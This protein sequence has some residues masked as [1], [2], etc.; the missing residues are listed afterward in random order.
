ML[1]LMLAGWL[2]LASTILPLT[3]AAQTNTET[4]SLKNIIHT[5]S[6]DKEKATAL[7]DL[8]WAYLSISID[9]ALHYGNLAVLASSQI[10]DR[11]IEAQARNDYGTALLL[12]GSLDAALSELRKALEIRTV[13]KDYSGS[14]SIRLKL[15]NCYYKAGKLD[16]AMQ[17]F[18]SALSYYEKENKAFETAQVKGNIGSL[19]FTMGNYSKSIEYQSQSAELL[20]SL[21]K[22]YELSNTLVNIGNTYLKKKD[23]SNAELHYQKA[24]TS[25]TT[26]GNKYA[27]SAALNNLSNIQIGR[28]EFT[29]AIKLAQE[30]IELRASMGME[31]EL[32]SGRTTLAIALNSTGNYQKAL[33]ELK[34]AQPFAESNGLTEQLISIYLQSA[35][36]YGGIHQADSMQHYLGLYESTKNSFTE[37]EMIKTSAELETRYQTARKDSV[38]EQNKAD[39]RFRNLA[40]AGI[41]VLFVLSLAIA[42]L[43]YKQ[44]KLR[45]N[46]QQMAQLNEQRMQ[47]S[48]ELHDNIGSYLTFIKSS[49]E[50]LEPSVSTATTALHNIRQLTDETISELRKTV[51]LMNNP[52][53]SVAEFNSKLQDYYKKIPKITVHPT[54]AHSELILGSTLSTQLFRIIQ[55]A[56]NNAMKHAE[57]ESVSIQL[58]NNMEAINLTI[59][60]NGKGMVSKDGQIGSGLRNLRERVQEFSG[61]LEIFSRPN[62]GTSLQIQLPIKQ[63]KQSV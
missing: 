51:W 1:R 35:I 31:G 5:T 3:L 21:N 48:R 18:T 54:G 55:E 19:Y 22:I 46:Q 2:L 59:R 60:D 12:K 7:S 20:E 34:L 29:E 58:Q 13:I 15:G 6:S 8:C 57:A 44:Q 24:I 56:V 38:L 9:S 14:A 30:S 63:L 26:A 41:S 50:Q 28:K 16:S 10:T 42:V 61:K 49:V 52:E 4:D 33:E 62:E 47:I 40:L 43:Y 23:S 39:L 37:N 32:A 11:K 27:H 25:A 36:A 53:V 45:T 17:Q